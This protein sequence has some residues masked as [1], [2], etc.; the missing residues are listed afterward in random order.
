[1]EDAQTRTSEIDTAD[2]EEASPRS[3]RPVFMRGPD[4][5][6]VTASGVPT[7]DEPPYPDP[8]A[9]LSRLGRYHLLH[10]IGQ[11]GM[12]V[13]YAGYDPELDRKVAL[14]ILR[15]EVA[16]REWLLREGQA[17]ARL[18]HP[19][20]VGIHEV[21]EHDGHVFLAM[22]FVEGQ[23]LTRWLEKKP[24]PLEI[25]R[26]FAQA[27][28]GLIAAHAAGLVHRDFKPDNV[29]IGK[30]GRV[31]VGDFGI[32]TQAGR[33]TTRKTE[34]A[35]SST[36]STPSSL[37]STPLTRAGSLV[38]TPAFMSPEQ[39]GGESI[40]ALSDQWSFCVAL[41][42]ATYQTSPFPSETVQELREKVLNESPVTPPLLP[43][44]P[45]WLSP[46]LLRG[47]AR[48]PADRYPD[49]AGLLAAIE[50]Y[51]PRDPELDPGVVVR[52]R[53]ILSGLVLGF[54][55]LYAVLYLIP[56][57]GRFLLSPPGLLSGA[58]LMCASF[59]SLAAFRWRYVSRNTYGRRLASTSVCLG[60][61]MLLNHSAGV[62]MGLPG[63]RVLI[64]DL[65]LLTVFN[66]IMA[67]TMESW[68]AILA[69]LSGT[70]ALAGSLAPERA[71][72]AFGAYALAGVTGLGLRLVLDRHMRPTQ[73]S[74]AAPPH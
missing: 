12:G 34:T 38:G 18:S 29:L 50:R 30:D 33:Q 2:I 73:S 61:L 67:C 52:E 58:A 72:W 51:L 43:D 66:A 49:M 42:D 71:T 62:A 36:T 65:V 21:G 20:V 74:A 57:T 60:L 48:N 25:L 56:T 1:M 53:Q 45:L 13:V 35:A 55:V 47:L 63:S 14:K 22:E 44:A 26:V 46:I 28:R 4:A 3:G 23:T 68:L 31:R 15:R 9:G 37:L 11:G 16:A 54:L 6:T 41:Y 19:N 40:T 27:G 39:F 69:A 10:R 64:E 7:A 59:V 5:P 24:Q 17:L 32:A 70:A 8:C